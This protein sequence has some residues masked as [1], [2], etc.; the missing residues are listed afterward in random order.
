M[1]LL[2]VTVQPRVH[3]LD[4]PYIKWPVT[5][6]PCDWQADPENYL[7]PL[8]VARIRKGLYLKEP[9]FPKTEG[10]NEYGFLKVFASRFSENKQW[11]GLMISSSDWLSQKVGE[12]RLLLYGYEC[13]GL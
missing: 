12:Q 7:Y 4:Y 3:H 8:F 2:F 5:E 13:M 9:I 6:E 10:C 11:I 1:S